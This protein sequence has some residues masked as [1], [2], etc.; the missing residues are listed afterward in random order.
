MNPERLMK[1]PA[2]FAAGFPFVGAAVKE[3]LGGDLPDGTL[4]ELIP[5]RNGMLSS[6]R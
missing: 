3:F 1:M 2:R 6:A 5:R 4:E